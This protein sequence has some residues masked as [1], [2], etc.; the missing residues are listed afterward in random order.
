MT[1]EVITEDGGWELELTICER[2]FERFMKRENLQAHF[3]EQQT[4]TV[5]VTAAT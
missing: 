5:P 1:G 3:L 4:A 2:D